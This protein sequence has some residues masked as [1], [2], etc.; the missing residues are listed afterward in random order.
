MLTNPSCPKKPKRNEIK[1]Q[2]T[3]KIGIESPK[4][5]EHRQLQFNLV[6]ISDS[7]ITI[8]YVHAPT[9]VKRYSELRKTIPMSHRA[10]QLYWVLPA[11]HMK[12]SWHTAGSY[13]ELSD[14]DDCGQLNPAKTMPCFN[15]CFVQY[16][17]QQ[18]IKPWSLWLANWRAKNSVACHRIDWCF[19]TLTKVVRPCQPFWSESLFG[20]WPRGLLTQVVTCQSKTRV[21]H[22]QEWLCTIPMWVSLS[23]FKCICRLDLA[24]LPDPWLSRTHYAAPQEV[25]SK[26]YLFSFSWL[27]AVNGS[28]SSKGQWK[29]FLSIR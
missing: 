7:F 25:A 16:Q 10:P 19:G 27:F 28:A 22:L 14:L 17:W 29:D 1:A 26:R 24:S 9:T 12:H 15:L 18:H 3:R 20:N 11:A 6:Y 13:Y 2:K 5:H 8:S 21:P 23:N 4:G